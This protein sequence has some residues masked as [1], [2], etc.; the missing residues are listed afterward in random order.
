MTENRIAISRNWGKKWEKKFI[1]INNNPYYKVEYITGLYKS[2]KDIIFASFKFNDESDSI[3]SKNSYDFFYNNKSNDL[4]SGLYYSKDFG[5][6]WSKSKINIPVS[7][8]EIDNNIY[9]A[10]IYPFCFYKYNFSE[11]FTEFSL[12]K[13][14]IL[15]NVTSKIVL[16]EYAKIL[17]N[18]IFK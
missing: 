16:E 6:N 2:D 14:G 8:W 15:D 12:Y 7:L 9:A 4:K 13:Y 17:L 5:N 10:P 1:K 3:L 18:L 11:E